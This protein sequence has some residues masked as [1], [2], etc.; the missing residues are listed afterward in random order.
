MR[1]ESKRAEAGTSTLSIAALAGGNL[2]PRSKEVAMAT[3]TMSG[4][5]P[6]MR[7]STREEAEDYRGFVAQLNDE[8]RVVVCRSAVQWILQRNGGYRHGAARWTPVGFYRSRQGLIAAVRVRCGQVDPDA[9][10]I[11]DALPAWIEEAAQ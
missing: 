10:E 2:N 7:T 1:P 8:W 6:A 5:V 11:I 3:I 4:T 9:A